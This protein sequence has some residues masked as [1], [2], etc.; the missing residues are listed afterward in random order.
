[1]K[2]TN[3]KLSLQAIEFWSTVCDE[4]IDRQLD[5][6]EGA[7]DT[8][9]YHFAKAAMPFVIPT[10][11]I[12]LTYQESEEDEDE[13]N[14]SKAAGTCLTLFANCVQDDM[15]GPNNAVFPFVE[16]NIS[17]N[18]WHH[19]EAAVMAFASVLDGPS[20]AL[21][22]PYV[23]QALPLLIK[24]LSDTSLAVKDTTAWAIGRICEILNEVIDLAEIPALI[25]VL[26]GGLKESP[27]VASHCA[28]AS[29]F[30]S[31]SLFLLSFLSLSIC[32]SIIT[33]DILVQQTRDHCLITL[34][35]SFF[36]TLRR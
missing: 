28:C 6:E 2:H 36:P 22:E 11:L 10:L 23:K 13:W 1:M 18:D 26:L 5:A 25:H 14:V 16:Q 35:F 21:I 12:L 9:I 15:L 7:D 31:F 20:P 3:E 19:R 29:R 17:S 27:R 8:V 4:E 34:L 33:I 24:M 30:P 32:L